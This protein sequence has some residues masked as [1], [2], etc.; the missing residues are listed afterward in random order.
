MV[1]LQYY[2]FKWQNILSASIFIPALTTIGVLINTF[3]SWAYSPDI[4]L[5]N[6]DFNVILTTTIIMGFFSMTLAVNP[7]WMVWV[8]R[9]CNLCKG[10]I[11]QLDDIDEEEERDDILD[12]D[13]IE[14]KI[15]K[16]TVEP[17]YTKKDNKDLELDEVDFAVGRTTSGILNKAYSIKEINPEDQKN[18][19]S[20]NI[21]K[22]SEEK[23]KMT[24][25]KSKPRKRIIIPILLGIV[26]LLFVVSPLVVAYL[27]TDLGRRKTAYIYYNDPIEQN[28]TTITQVILT[29]N[30]IS[31]LFLCIL[32]M[33]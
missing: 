20:K 24:Q 25:E 21:D 31:H 6:E 16:E 1:K 29:E 7:S 4:I 23:E 27:L 18:A 9:S 12:G 13:K 2:T 3:P 11:S 17:R 28:K 22:R 14:K 19:A 26:C 15:H 10:L 30:I 8:G 32:H 33:L 5:K